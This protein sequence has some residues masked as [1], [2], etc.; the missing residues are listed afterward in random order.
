MAVQAVWC[1]TSTPVHDDPEGVGKPLLL[2]NGKG[3]PNC[4]VLE[5]AQAPLP[6]CSDQIAGVLVSRTELEI[7]V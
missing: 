2:T 4:A 7:C 3:T 6:S 5:L 1:A